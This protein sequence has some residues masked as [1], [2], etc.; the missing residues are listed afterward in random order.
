MWCRVVGQIGGLYV[1]L[2]TEDGYVVMD[3]HAA[4]ERILFERF[5][6]DFLDG[7]MQTQGL[8]IPETVDLPPKDAVR[9]RKSLELFKKMGFGV[10]EFGGDSCR[11]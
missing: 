3:P 4:H 6:K 8:L 2:E 7:K 9:I 1:V 10:S 5:M 11:S